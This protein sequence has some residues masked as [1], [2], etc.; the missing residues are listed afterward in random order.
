MRPT[1][2]LAVCCLATA[3]AAGDAPPVVAA[4]VGF[5]AGAALD[6]TKP[7]FDAVGDGKTDCTAAFQKAMALM[8]QKNNGGVMYLPK[9][10][11]LV[12]DSL[13]LWR[14]AK[15]TA[16][17]GAGVGQT[18]IRLKDG[19]PGFGDPSKPKPV[20]SFGLDPAQRFRNC[21]YDLTVHT[22]SGNPGAVGVQH[23]TSNQGAMMR[24]E[25]VSGDGAGAV[26]LDLAYQ[27]QIGPGLIQDLRVSGFS[28]G[29]KAKPLNSMTFERILLEN[30]KTC[31]IE[32][33]GDVLVIRGLTVKGAPVAI[34][35]AGIMTLVEAKLEGASGP[36]I[37]NTGELYARDI[38]VVGY[39]P[40]I[41]NK[42]KEANYDGSGPA[43]PDAA[44]P[45]VAEW[46]SSEPTGIGPKPFASLRLPIADAPAIP[47]DDPKN[48]ASPLD[49]GAV[50]DGQAD[51]TAAIQKAID[52]GATTVYLPRYRDNNGTPAAFGAKGDIILRGKVRRFFGSDGFTLNHIGEGKANLIVGDGDGP[53]AI[54][55][56][57]LL[58]R[59]IGIT[60]KGN[61]PLVVNNITMHHDF[62]VSESAA[63]LFM[64]DVC[65]KANFKKPGQRVFMRQINVED[66]EVNLVSN[67]A[68][69]WI[70]GL[71]TERGAIKVDAKGGK[72]EILGGFAYC[73]ENT[74]K[75]TFVRA[76]DTP[77]TVAGLAQLAFGNPFYKYFASGTI[78]GIAYKQ[79][80]T[81]FFDGA[82]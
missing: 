15:R 26:G 75:D 13:A 67:G 5:P 19:A 22:G 60:H 49:F 62:F 52:S 11:Y 9:G 54:E 6:L 51:D 36:A 35:N 70:L 24:V 38:E 42:R 55:R 2:I 23:Y 17:Q 10:T 37:L 7:P 64:N 28:V 71:K 4:P 45:K 40:A 39:A 34:R 59:Q 58:Y 80:E 1:L 43:L 50:G 47:W 65:V 21:M 82:P 30:I 76:I 66:K 57:D 63:D 69:L 25:I 72:V 8:S 3:L 56:I 73:T 14:D 18:I 53:V 78:K 74:V 33:L 29:I 46:F 44:G 77:V 12:S 20:F 79:A 32:G 27:R 48:W 16:W 61:R 68:V 41:S 31:G 81:L